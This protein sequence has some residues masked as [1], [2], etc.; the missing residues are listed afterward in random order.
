LEHVIGQ[1]I[2]TLVR[3]L[4]ALKV[5]IVGEQVVEDVEEET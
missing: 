5:R 3:L 1:D 4:D 2:Q